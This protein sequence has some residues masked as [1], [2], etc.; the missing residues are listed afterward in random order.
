MEHVRNVSVPCKFLP[1]K[2]TLS[3]TLHSNNSRFG[4]CSLSSLE[5]G[6]GWYPGQSST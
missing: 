4:D 1:R 2:R 5:L 6:D 3:W